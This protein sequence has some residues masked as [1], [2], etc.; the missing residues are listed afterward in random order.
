MR[1]L[2]S[3]VFFVYASVLVEASGH[4]SFEVVRMANK[5]GDGQHA[6]LARR[7]RSGN[8][9]CGPRSQHKVRMISST[10]CSRVAEGGRLQNQTT[11]TKTDTADPTG[12][13]SNYGAMS[14]LSQGIISVLSSCGP[15]GA[16]CES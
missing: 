3:L 1:T 6:R 7:A 9:R 14:I 13:D 12:V 15:I 4:S 2:T 10:L 8:G 5:H 16:T 11:T